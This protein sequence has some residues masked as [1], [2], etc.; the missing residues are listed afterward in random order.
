MHILLQQR[1]CLRMG[2]WVW[3]GGFQEVRQKGMKLQPEYQTQRDVQS[4]T[5]EM[6]GLYLGASEPMPLMA[7][8]EEKNYLRSPSEMRIGCQESETVWG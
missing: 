3:E 8:G 5:F 7:S 1:G 6:K 2:F 4:H